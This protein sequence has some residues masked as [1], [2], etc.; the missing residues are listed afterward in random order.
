[1]T[2]EMIDRLVN[3]LGGYGLT[4][5]VLHNIIRIFFR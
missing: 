5:V 2:I 4:M 1:M 3:G